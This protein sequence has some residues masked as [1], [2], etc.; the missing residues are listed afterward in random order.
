MSSKTRGTLPHELSKLVFVA[1]TVAATA[2]TGVSALANPGDLD[3]AFGSGGK[4]TTNFG[5]TGG[6]SWGDRAQGVLIQP[7]GKIVAAGST[8]LGGSSSNFALL[9]YSSAGVPDSGFGS[10]GKVTT[11]FGGADFGSAIARQGDGKILVAG[12]TE[13]SVALARYGTGGTLDSTFGSGGKISTQVSGAAAFGYAV[14]VQPDGKI[15][16][17]GSADDGTAASILVLRYSANGTLDPSFG[18]GGLTKS[19]VPGLN[20]NAYAVSLDA[21]GKIVVAGAVDSDAGADFI[22]ARYTSAGILDSSFG[23]SGKV[24]TSFSGFDYAYALAIQPDGKVIAAGTAQNGSG[25]NFALAR[26]N[27]NGTLDS[28]FGSS[29]KV[30]TSFSPL[31][32]NAVTSGAAGA[33][34]LQGDRIIAAGNAG[35]SGGAE[36]FAVARYQSDG[37]PEP[38]FG[39]AGKAVTSIGGVDDE[40]NAAALQS[41]GKLVVAGVSYSNTTAS[42]DFGVVRYQTTY[43][44][45]A[46]LRLKQTGPA[47]TIPVGGDMSFTTTITNDGPQAATNAAIVDSFPSTVTFKSATPSQGSCSFAG[48]RLTCALGTVN[49]LANA[50]VTVVVGPTVGGTVKSVSSATSSLSDPYANNS[51][52]VSARA[53]KTSSP[54]FKTKARGQTA[55]PDPAGFGAASS[56][57][58]ASEQ[59]GYVSLAVSASDTLPAGASSGST[60][61]G[62]SRATAFTNVTGDGLTVGGAS[63]FSVSAVISNV[64]ATSDV[65]ADVASVPSVRYGA[66]SV[67]ARMTVTFYPCSATNLCSPQGTVSA[68]AALSLPGLSTRTVTLTT[69]LTPPSSFTGTGILS[70]NVG[71]VADATA[72]GAAHASASVNGTVSQLS[73]Y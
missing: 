60:T 33:V 37:S 8:D 64:H 52:T 44:S 50:S 23:S 4:V 15:V 59:N 55:T 38:T 66:V 49:Y 42:A 39:S 24:T 6:V 31:F 13:T 35:A 11:D 16:V 65:A 32:S 45:G 21:A 28:S 41:D 34:L 67:T 72:C 10:G 7:D 48:G 25:T 46:D 57:A 22:V 29:G 73:A 27:A 9:R 5:A 47:A 51:S 12:G 1:C 18:T 26:Y 20:A 70:V 53:L 63:A 19:P 40:G 61:A 17:A 2:L 56:S 71:F 54:P 68:S 36:R 3:A 58:S 43:P 62:I 30:S 69:S 14:L